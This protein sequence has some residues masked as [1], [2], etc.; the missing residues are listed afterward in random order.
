MP[1]SEHVHSKPFP[2]ICHC[3]ARPSHFH[4]RAALH[5]AALQCLHAL[6]F[7]ALGWLFP[8]PC[9][10]Y[11]APTQRATIFSAIMRATF[12]APLQSSIQNSSPG[13]LH[14]LPYLPFVP[15]PP[16]CAS[17][18][19]QAVAHC[20]PIGPDGDP[21]PV[22][23]AAQPV[24]PA[25]CFLYASTPAYTRVNSALHPACPATCFH[26]RLLRACTNFDRAVN[27]PAP[28]RECTCCAHRDTF[29]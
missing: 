18:G 17:R 13:P 4:L 21:S 9:L 22:R 12:N 23:F 5:T 27:A 28:H 1:P 3:L 10:P 19:P 26:M 25:Q 16:A 6:T 29:E 14:P 24:P 2:P 15:H 7:P 11:C 20:K 8:R